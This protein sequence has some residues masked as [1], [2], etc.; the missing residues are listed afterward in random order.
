M[1]AD[2]ARSGLPLV[3]RRYIPCD[4]LEL[5]QDDPEQPKRLSWYAALFDSLS[6]DLGG[7]RERIGRRAFSKTVQEHDVRALINHDPNL[8]LGR[9][10]AKTL[11]LAVDMTGLHANVA[12]PDTSYARDLVVNI[13]NGNITGGSF[14]FSTVRDAWGLEDVNGEETV[15]RTVNEVRLYDVSPVTF[16]A[17]P[18]TEGLASVRSLAL[19]WREKLKAPAPAAETREM[20][21][22]AAMQGMCGAC[23]VSEDECQMKQSMSGDMKMDRSLISRQRRILE[24]LKLR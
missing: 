14:M 20:A 11:K 23:G 1:D 12:L 24:L 17:Y 13:E 3:E 18:A 2:K 7:F 6:E 9:T 16:P 8:V 5:R 22:C 10:S 21:M 15:V 4:A 19:E